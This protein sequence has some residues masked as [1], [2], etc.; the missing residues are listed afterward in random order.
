MV[1]FAKDNDYL[2]RNRLAHE[3]HEIARA[4]GSDRT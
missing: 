1:D 4:G 3:N 2:F